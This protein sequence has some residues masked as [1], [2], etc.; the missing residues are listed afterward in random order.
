VATAVCPAGEFPALGAF[1]FSTGAIRW[2][3]CSA[4]ETYR[5]IVGTLPDVVLVREST[6]YPEGVTIAYDTEDGTELWRRATQAMPIPRG[7]AGGQGVVVLSADDGGA[8]AV[9]GLDADSGEERWRLPNPAVVLGLTDTVAIVADGTPEGRLG[10]ARGIDLATGAELWTSDIRLD[11][12]S[13]VGVARGAAAVSEDLIAIPTG[14]TTTAIDTRSGEVRW[15][16]PQLNHPEAASG[17]VVG[18]MPSSRPPYTLAAV[19][20]STGERL[21]SDPGDPSYGDVLAVGD[22]IVVALDGG[23]FVAYDLITGAVRWRAE[24]GVDGRAEPQ[25]IDGQSLVTLW[26]GILAVR[27]TVDGSIRWSAQEPLNSPLMSSAG[28]N[29]STLFVA[30]NSLPW[31]D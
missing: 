1:D 18:T 24:P 2:S 22:G 26:N 7:V 9:L 11:D 14:A 25:H 17:A 20:A 23:G 5:S 28:S 31:R 13:G 27:S 30:V 8:P 6:A 29:G 19:D 10:G 15:T 3:F 4:E 16:R 12:R 21:W